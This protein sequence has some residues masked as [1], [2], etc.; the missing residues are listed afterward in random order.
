MASPAHFQP[1]RV[2]LLLLAGG[3]VAILFAALVLWLAVGR[4]KVSVLLLLAVLVLV[5]A[6]VCALALDARLRADLES[7]NEGLR[8]IMVG[9]FAG[10]PVKEGLLK[11]TP[12]LLDRVAAALETRERAVRTFGPE[13]EPSQSLAWVDS[14]EAPAEAFGAVVLQARWLDADGVLAGLDPGMHVAGLG[15]FYECVLETLRL[16]GGR[17]LELGGGKILAVWETPDP[18]FPKVEGLEPS[19]AIPLR[20]GWQLRKSLSVLASQHRLRHGFVLEWSLALAQGPLVRG[21][22]GPRGHR[23]WVCS[24]SPLAEVQA[25]GSRS[26]GPWLGGDIAGR[27]GGSY[28]AQQVEGVSLLVSGPE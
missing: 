2:R 1:L 6:L 13:V 3:P 10:L 17:V 27:C 8:Q 11:E 5:V 4:P 23:R 16:S 15:R 14:L 12:A 7:L 28:V 22:W 18:A 25:L 26:N 21:G 24:G 19:L 9:R 20:C